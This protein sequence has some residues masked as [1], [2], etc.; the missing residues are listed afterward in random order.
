MRR[1]FIEKENIWKILAISFVFLSLLPFQYFL[2]WLI[3]LVVLFFLFR[4]NRSQYKD[5]I[6]TDSNVCL[7]PIDGRVVGLRQLHAKDGE[8]NLEMKMHMSFFG[9]YGLICPCDAVVE[10]VAQQKVERKNSLFQAYFSYKIIFKN[11]LGNK[12]MI[13]ISKLPIF[14]SPKIW[15]QAGDKTRAGGCFGYLPYGGT[16]K[17][18]FSTDVKTAIEKRSRLIAGETI[19]AG[20]RGEND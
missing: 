18:Y 8:Y 6:A 19:V 10:E 3:C 20:M 5:F 13:K 12:V 1:F 4:T 16:V 11:K 15:I 17:I 14:A 9:P 2:L 7:A